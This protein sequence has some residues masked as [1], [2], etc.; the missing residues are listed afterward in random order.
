MAEEIATI[1]GNPGPSEDKPAQE[2][3]EP[4]TKKV[5][6]S[7]AQKK[8]LARTKDASLKGQNK[9]RQFIHV[10]DKVDICWRFSAGETC[11]SGARYMF[12]S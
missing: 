8:R 5:K 10:S 7:G 3:E 6:L 2:S 12:C 1:A 11:P 9:N 4:P